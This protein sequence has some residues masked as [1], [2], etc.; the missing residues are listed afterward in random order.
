[1]SRYRWGW[2][3]APRELPQPLGR[4]W[5][6]HLEKHALLTCQGLGYTPFARHYLGYLH[7]LES[8]C[9]RQAQVLISF[10]PPTE[11]FHFG[12]F[13]PVRIPKKVYAFCRCPAYNWAGSPI[14]E[15]RA[16][17]GSRRL[18]R[19]YRSLARPSSACGPKASTPCPSLLTPA[20]RPDCQCTPTVE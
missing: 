11:M 1:M 8:R 4:N 19:A 20:H 17:N 15:S 14:R 16:N 7:L 10:P 9:L 3:G 12:G 13:P 18:T 5:P 2:V 6:N